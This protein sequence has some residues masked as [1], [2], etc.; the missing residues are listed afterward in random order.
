MPVYVDTPG[1]TVRPFHTMHEVEEFCEVFFDDVL[2]P[3]DRTVGA[4]GQGWA[5]AMALL[6]MERASSMWLRTAF[7]HNRLQRLVSQAA[8]GA[9]DPRELGDA[10][11]QL[12]ALRAQSRT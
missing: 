11:A 5:L 8:P 9:I 10:I 7:L 6:P 1:I 12:A 2:V 3:F 4:E